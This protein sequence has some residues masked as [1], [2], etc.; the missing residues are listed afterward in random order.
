VN[1]FILPLLYVSNAAVF[2][3]SFLFICLGAHLCICAS[4]ITVNRSHCH[5]GCTQVGG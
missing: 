3:S 2:V 1:Q 4:E 5:R